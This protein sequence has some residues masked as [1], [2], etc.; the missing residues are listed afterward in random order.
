MSKSYQQFKKEVLNDKETREAYERLSP[1]FDFIH[2]LI[3]KRIE[4]GLSQQ[5]LA[6]K[7]GTKQSAIS[8]LESGR[9]NP[10][11]KVLNK[12]AQALDSKIKI[13]IN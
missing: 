11:F 3:Q 7:I 2:S 12:V 8:R 5:E 9:Y 10:T 1:E 4:K 13:S 6:Q